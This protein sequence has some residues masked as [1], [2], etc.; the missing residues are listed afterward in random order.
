MTA[1]NK[2]VRRYWVMKSEPSAFSIDDLKKQRK[3]SW[4]GIRNYQVRNL[5]RDEI[6]VGDIALFYHSSSDS[7]GVAG[8]MEVIS[9]AYADLTQFNKKD[10]HF[11]PKSSKDDPTWL[12][13][14]VK[15]IEKYNQIILLKDIKSLP[16]MKDSRL[17][18]RGNRLSVFEISKEQYEAVKALAEV[19]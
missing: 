1:T 19:G 9:Q 2:Q 17:V 16:V 11:D 7:I 10:S 3:T 15:F 18:S 5:I 13:L 14:D 12:C 6:S 8:E 4:D